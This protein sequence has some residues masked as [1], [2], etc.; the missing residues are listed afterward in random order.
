MNYISPVEYG[1]SLNLTTLCAHAMTDS[2]KLVIAC[3]VWVL[4]VHNM[5]YG[6]GYSID[7]YGHHEC[8]REG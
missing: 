3:K 8:E 2:P 4:Y 1:A 7:I 6:C 5:S